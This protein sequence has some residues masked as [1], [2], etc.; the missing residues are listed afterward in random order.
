MPTIAKALGRS[1]STIADHVFK[2]NTMSKPVGA[3][4]KMTVAV[5]GRLKKAMDDLQEKANG[6]KEVAI[7]MIKKRAR[8][9]LSNRTISDKFHE[10]GIHF[11]RLK[12]RCS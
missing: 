1:K 6:L 3:P 9:R 8:V 12:A 2:K 5:F 4:K 7:A 10:E 11:R